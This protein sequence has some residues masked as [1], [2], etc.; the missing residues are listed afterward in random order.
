MSVTAHAKTIVK[1]RTDTETGE[2]AAVQIPDHVDILVSNPAACMG[3]SG[4]I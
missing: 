4:S 1:V 3:V 2:P